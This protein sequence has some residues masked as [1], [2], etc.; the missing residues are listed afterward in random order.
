MSSASLAECWPPDGRPAP[1]VRSARLAA[2]L[3]LSLLG[4]L[5]MVALLPGRRV[6]A[7]APLPPFALEVRLP[8]TAA[9]PRR[10][11]L[12]RPAMLQPA[13]AHP[14]IAR[15]ADRAAAPPSA[16]AAPIVAAPLLAPPAQTAPTAQPAPLAAPPAALQP[17][18]PSSPPAEAGLSTGAPAAA[19][20]PVGPL[21][22]YQAIVRGAA[23]E[24]EAAPPGPSST[25]ALPP[26]IE[27]AFAG[28]LSRHPVAYTEIRL[29]EGGSMIVMPAGGCMV[30]DGPVTALTPSE[31]RMVRYTT[32]AMDQRCP[33]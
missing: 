17:S 4:H 15:P 26:S 30:T 7:P 1:T 11:A 10:P 5:L 32:H 18:G 25:P 28:K 12:Q 22:D 23:H 9:A 24:L 33:Q 20:A 27:Q 3:G 2:A 21:R 13:P 6:A 14:A 29:A 31:R 19:A 16:V 8:A